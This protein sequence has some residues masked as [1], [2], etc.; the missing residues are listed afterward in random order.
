MAFAATGEV[1]FR[2]TMLRPQPLSL[3]LAVLALALAVLALALLAAPGL[4]HRAALVGLVSFVAAWIHLALAW[5]VPL[6]VLVF[7]ASALAHRQRPD[8]GAASAAAAG[9][10]VGWLLRPNPLGSLRLAWIQ[11]GLFLELKR[12]GLALPFGLE[13]QPL[14]PTL[15]LPRL[16]LPGLALLAMLAAFGIR[17]RRQPASGAPLRIAAWTSLGLGLFFALLSV[18]VASRSIELA[19]AFLGPRSPA[20]SSPSAG[21]QPRGEPERQPRSC[22]R[23]CWR[24]SPRWQPPATLRASRKPGR[25]SHSGE[26]RSGWRRTAVPAS[27]C[28]TPGGTSSH[29]CS[30]GTRRGSTPAWRRTASSGAC[31][32]TAPTWFIG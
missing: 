20:R 28:S 30:S 1:L 9:S 8:W 25:S 31:S 14:S 4:R 5:L 7:A 10:L 11:V 24:S 6:V 23:W 26:R 12:R 17:L 13:L 18:R 22:S 15:E 29:T 32:T 19:A 16:V 27:W 3:A 21:R 2:L